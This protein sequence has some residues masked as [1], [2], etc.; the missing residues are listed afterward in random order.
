MKRGFWLARW[1][2]A[3][4]IEAYVI[5]PSSIHPSSVAVPR[6]HRRV[7]TDRLDT[8]LLMRAFLGWLR[9]ERRHCSMAA[10]PTIEEEDAKRPNRER[11][12]LVGERTRTVNRIKATLARFGIHTFKPT[13]RRLKIGS[14]AC[15][16]GKG[17]LFLKIRKQSCAATWCACV[18]SLHRSRKSSKNACAS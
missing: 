4:D 14:L 7:K 10:I 16:P 17:R 8:E 1:L 18:S 11:E 3:R 13:L 6:E 15:R 2:L 12:K 9:G 5:H